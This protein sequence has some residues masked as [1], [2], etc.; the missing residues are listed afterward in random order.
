H[1]SGI[2]CPMTSGLILRKLVKRHIGLDLDVDIPTRLYLDVWVGRLRQVDDQRTGRRYDDRVVVLG[3]C[4]DPILCARHDVLLFTI[5]V[6]Q[7]R[8]ASVLARRWR[9]RWYGG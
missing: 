3:K 8:K 9:C 4:N 2:V 5:V 6:S 7:I 1:S